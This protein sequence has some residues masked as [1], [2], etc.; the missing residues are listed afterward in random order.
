M[1]EAR[2]AIVVMG[3]C[4]CGKSSV[5][6]ELATRL[7]AP[8]VEGDALHPA[9]NVAKMAAGAALTDADRGPWLDALAARIAEEAAPVVVVAC[10]ALKRAYRDRLRDGAGREVAFLYLHGSR[11]LLAARMG[12]REGHF[13]P[14]ALL[15]SQLATLED[16]RG[17]AGVATVGIDAPPAAIATAALATPEIGGAPA[18]R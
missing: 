17:E 6:A 2:R 3:V 10:S 16:P 13:M 9:A 15:D 18:V 4:G 11:E 7:G 8:F 5:G 14:P 1:P 12:A